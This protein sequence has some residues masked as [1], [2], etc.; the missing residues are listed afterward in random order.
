MPLNE[1]KPKNK[2]TNK[3]KNT[4]KTL[5]GRLVL[6]EKAAEIKKGSLTSRK[7]K[8]QVSLHP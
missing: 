5:A 3:Q 4:W 1:K 8:K 6:R 7:K 2:K